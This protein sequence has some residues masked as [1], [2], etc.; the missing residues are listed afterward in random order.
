MDS[1]LLLCWL[2]GKQMPRTTTT[3]ALHVLST[4][5]SKRMPPKEEAKTS[6]NY[7]EAITKCK[8]KGNMYYTFITHLNTDKYT[9]FVI[10]PRI[11][12]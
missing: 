11:L 12:G 6:I 4:F 7:M 8:Y 3:A 9:Q 2:K 5:F 10:S 1:V